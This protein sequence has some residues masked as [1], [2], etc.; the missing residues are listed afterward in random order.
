LS[1][2]IETKLFGVGLATAVLLHATIP[3]P[4]LVRSDDD[5]RQGKAEGRIRAKHG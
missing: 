5:A 2:G 3:R 4:V 1:P